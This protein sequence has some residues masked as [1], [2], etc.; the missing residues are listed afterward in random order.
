MKQPEKKGLIIGLTGQT[1]AG[2]S[3]VSTMLSDR[4]YSVI[5]ADI[6]ARQVVTHGSKCLLDLAVE[7]GIEILE[8][9][10][11]LNR[12]KLGDMV[13]HDKHKRQ[14][15][16]QITFPYIQEEIFAQTEKKINAGEPVVF[17]DAPTLF[18]SGANAY[19]NKICSV[20]APLETRLI[21][22]TH[23]DKITNE[24]ALARINAQHDDEYYTSRSDF[25]IHNDGDLSD[26]RVLV[27]E[28]LAFFGIKSGDDSQ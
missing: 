16:N 19:C 13:F 8:A 11:T 15:L 7:F 21:R 18:E 24:D 22:I 5:D 20:I 9:E 27:M 14:R 17:L 23:R 6:V 4:G 12:R 3:L 26:L 1:G 25:V 2:K 28:M 10:G